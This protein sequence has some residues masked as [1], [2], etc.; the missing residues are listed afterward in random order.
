MI[1]SVLSEFSCL[2]NIGVE[3]DA[4]RVDAKNRSELLQRPCIVMPIHLKVEGEIGGVEAIKGIEFL[5]VT[6][7][8]VGRQ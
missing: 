2:C 4:G 6:R 5:Y 1:N 3:L 7:I 8:D